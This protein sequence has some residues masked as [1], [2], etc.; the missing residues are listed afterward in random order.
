VARHPGSIPPHQTRALRVLWTS[1]TCLSKGP[2]QGIDELSLRVRVGWLTRT[3]VI[4]PRSV[5]RAYR[6]KCVTGRSRRWPSMVTST[7]SL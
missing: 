6:K 4:Q 3:E 5:T 2:S 7:F 1:A